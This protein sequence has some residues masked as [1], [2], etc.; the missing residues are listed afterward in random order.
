MY[1]YIHIYIY[2][3]NVMVHSVLT[4]CTAVLTA[5]LLD[6]QEILLAVGGGLL[7]A[8][9]AL[10]LFSFLLLDRAIFHGGTSG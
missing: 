9:G 2:G 3:P 1:V 8:T 10:P 4:G 5:A 7:P 6:L